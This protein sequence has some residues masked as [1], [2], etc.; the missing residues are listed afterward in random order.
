MSFSPVAKA[1][2]RSSQGPR[3]DKVVAGSQMTHPSHLDRLGSADGVRGR[4]VRGSTD[5]PRMWTVS[6]TGIV[7]EHLRHHWTSDQR[8]EFGFERVSLALFVHLVAADIE[9]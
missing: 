2:L 7:P 1:G 9:R 8:L 6:G 5:L 4:P 3:P